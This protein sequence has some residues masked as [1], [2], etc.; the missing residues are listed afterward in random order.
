[1]FAR[2]SSLKVWGE[3]ILP[4]YYHFGIGLASIPG[5]VFVMKFTVSSCRMLHTVDSLPALVT[6]SVGRFL[7]LLLLVTASCCC[8]LLLLLVAASCCCPLFQ[9]CSQQAW[10]ASVRV[11]TMNF[12]ITW[13]P[14]VNRDAKIIRAKRI[15]RG[16]MQMKYYFCQT[17]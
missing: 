5:F 15:V 12:I 16:K 10:T 6:A 4:Y 3:N 7:L 9:R 1:M 17:F 13:A 14:A 11:H 2:T 8:F